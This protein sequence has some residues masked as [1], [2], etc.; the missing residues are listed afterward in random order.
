MARS[1]A[2]GRNVPG[3]A[4]ALSL[5]L[6]LGL[7]WSAGASEALAA[8]CEPVATGSALVAAPPDERAASLP[9]P[10]QP[11][12]RS[13]DQERLLAETQRLVSAQLAEIG[14]SECYAALVPTIAARTA[15]LSPFEFL[16][17][18]Q[19]DNDWVRRDS[20]LRLYRDDPQ[21]AMREISSF[22]PS[23]RAELVVSTP[24]FFDVDANQVFVNLGALTEEQALNVLVHEFWHALTDVRVEALPDGSHVRTTGFWTEHRAADARAWRP[25][26][27]QIVG[28]ISTY[29]MNEAVAS[30]MEITATGSDHFGMRPD[31]LR[32][33]AALHHLFDRGGRERVLRLYLES[34]SDEL[35]EL[36]LL[37][38][39]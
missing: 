27:E 12:A 15:F 39:R 3:R 5:T 29:L 20:L 21:Q 10:F 31:L 38:S 22:W 2:H 18:A 25:I 14:A 37:A 8:P 6:A 30:E 11:Q 4:L 16:V 32:A 33:R 26:D 1:D 23:N 36:A 34:R 13:I 19:Y 9:R 24:G 28:G 35:K 7:I 17:V